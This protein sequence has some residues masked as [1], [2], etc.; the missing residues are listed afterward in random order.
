MQN[1]IFFII[2]NILFWVSNLQAQAS[3]NILF[4]TSNQHT[5]GTTNLNAA[6]HFAE[7][8]LA[9]H[10]FVT[11]GFSVDFMSPEG[12][13]IPIGYLQTSDK[14][15]K[16]YLY[17]T[18]FMNKLKH[19]KAPKE[20]EAS[21]YDA[22]YYS[23]GGAA[24]FGVPENKVIQEIAMEIYANQGIVAAICHGTAGIVHLKTKAG[25]SLYQGKKITGFPD[26]FE[27]KDAQYYQT[28]P[29][30]IEKQIE[31]SGGNFMYSKEGWD[32]FYVIDGNLFTGQD[33]SATTKLAEEIVKKLNSNKL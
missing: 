3:R 2:L 9:Y 1:R 30:S 10:V 21:T 15:Q 25:Q 4:V 18:N 8:T 31:E 7:I 23:G 5:Y 24:M 6:N 22:V 26:D 11:N 12:G 29:F 33:P 27:R 32:G 13:A 16:Q 28:F 17:D 14:I 19:T 20:I